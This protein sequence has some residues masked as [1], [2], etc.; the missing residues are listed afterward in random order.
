MHVHTHVFI[1]TKAENQIK[2]LFAVGFIH[3]HSL[4]ILIYM[5]R[6]SNKGI[7]NSKAC[8]LKKFVFD[9]PII[10]YESPMIM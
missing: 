3:Y 4:L 8:F 5:E 6:H 10:R 7:L 2:I 9:E 1:F